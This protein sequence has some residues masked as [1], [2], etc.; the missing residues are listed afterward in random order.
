MIEAV[1]QGQ[2]PHGWIE[3]AVGD[4]GATVEILDS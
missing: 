4:Y 1:L 3:I 2:Q